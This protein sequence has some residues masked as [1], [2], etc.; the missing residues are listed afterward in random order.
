[1]PSPASSRGIAA[2]DQVDVDAALGE[3]VE[4]GDHAGHLGGQDVARSGGDEHLELRRFGRHHRGRDPGLPAGG[5]DGDEGVLEA[6]RLGGEGDAFE[7]L[8]GGG[9]ELVGVG[10]VGQVA[11]CGD[12]P[13]EA[14]VGVGH[15]VFQVIASLAKFTTGGGRVE[16][17]GRLA[18]RKKRKREKK[19]SEADYQG[20]SSSSRDSSSCGEPPS[21][22][23]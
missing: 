17:G 23:P 14:D 7:H 5:R 15:E 16:A 4:G 2:S 13:A 9:D 11:V 10:E 1:M 3:L 22:T 20:S 6:G 12:V 8:H 21:V 19:E 18:P